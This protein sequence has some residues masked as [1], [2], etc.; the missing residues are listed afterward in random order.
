[1]TNLFDTYNTELWRVFVAE[2]KAH[3]AAEYA[4]EQARRDEREQDFEA[5]YAEW[6]ELPF[7][8]RWIVHEPQRYWESN[9]YL[10]MGSFILPITVDRFL[11]WAD[12]RETTSITD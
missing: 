7:W 6:I 12:K 3:N 2:T 8:R 5:R 9:H 1:M 11:F 4:A 10:E